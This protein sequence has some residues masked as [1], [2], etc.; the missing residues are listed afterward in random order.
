MNRLQRLPAKDQW[1]VSLNPDQD[2]APGT[3][4]YETLYEHPVYTM[5]SSA[6]QR[7]LPSISGRRQ[8]YFCGSYHG[9]GFHED[10]ARSAVDVVHKHFGITP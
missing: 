7:L 1:L 10:G 2:C 3:Q 8:T 5:E 4:A 6:T 9:Y